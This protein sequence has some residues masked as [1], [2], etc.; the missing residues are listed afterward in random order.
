M[1]LP[2]AL[3]ELHEAFLQPLQFW[4]CDCS[5]ESI[6]YTVACCRDGEHKLQLERLFISSMNCDAD[7]SHSIGYIDRL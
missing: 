4:L 7:D 5:G 6:A 2:L 3:V 1:R